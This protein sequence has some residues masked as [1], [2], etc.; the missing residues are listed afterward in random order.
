[1]NVLSI[2]EKIR[3]IR[4]SL[5]MTLKDLAGNRVT[6]GQISLIESGKSNP[7]MDLLEYLSIKLGTSIE[8][9]LESEQKQAKKICDYYENIALCHLFQGN[10]LEVESYLYKMVLIS[11]EYDLEEVLY[12][13]YFIRG[14]CL[15]KTENYDLAVENF[16]L[17]NFGFLKFSMNEELVNSFL[18]LA[19]ISVNKKNY[20]SAIIHLKCAIKII[21]KYFVNYDLS[22]FKVYYLISK[23]YAEIGN[24]DK[25]SYYL[26][27]L[28]RLLDKVYRPKE[29]ALIFMEKSIEYMELEDLD[30]AVKFS[31]ISRKCFEDI[32]LINDRQVIENDVSKYLIEKNELNTCKTYL[33]RAEG[34]GIFYGFDNLFEIYK[35]FIN[36][37]IKKNDIEK[38][39]Y[40]LTKLEN[41]VDMKNFNNTI[42]FYMLKYKF[43]IIEKNYADAEVI[44][45]L[46][47][48]FSRDFGEYK[49]AGDCCLALSKFYLD[50]K[51]I[52]EAENIISEALVQYRKNGYKINL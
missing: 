43:H 30:N 46:A 15:Y 49:K 33:K 38:M 3:K 45:I 52:N 11:K 44:L 10:I 21:D 39:K 25:S 19:N 1:M 41:L 20:I 14:L 12:K 40:Y 35:N 31:N 13:N 47:Y 9:L 23:S 36:L 37:Y 51:R 34:F 18:Y 16:L 50:R 27:K 2:G 22:F 42:D 5:D 32:I 17:A 26:E 8:Y 29:S 28:V 48:N 4:K 6:T 24:V 7:S